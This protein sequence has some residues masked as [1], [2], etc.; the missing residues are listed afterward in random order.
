ML[1]LLLLSAIVLVGCAHTPTVQSDPRIVELQTN[2]QDNTLATLNMAYA[3][4]VDAYVY[5]QAQ[6]HTMDA[7][8]WAAEATKQY[9]HLVRL[10]ET[11]EQLQR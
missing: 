5:W 9:N 11:I 6:Q 2:M 1:R 4:A 8:V 10:R 7:T 3:L